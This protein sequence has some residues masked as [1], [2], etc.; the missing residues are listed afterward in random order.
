MS[1]ENHYLFEF[2]F[3]RVEDSR[4]CLKNGGEDGMMQYCS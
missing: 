1:G 3:F 2:L 4:L